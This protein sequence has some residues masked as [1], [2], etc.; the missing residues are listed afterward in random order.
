MKEKPC[1]ANTGA[2]CS[3]GCDEAI[4]VGKCTLGLAPVQGPDQPLAYMSVGV[5]LPE[6]QIELPRAFPGNA[7]Y[8]LFLFL[9]WPFGALFSFNSGIFDNLVRIHTG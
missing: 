8:G 9:L 6:R 7:F 5:S 3:T 4:Y 2:S 1:G